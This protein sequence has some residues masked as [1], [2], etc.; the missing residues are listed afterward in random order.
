MRETEVREKA[1]ENREKQSQGIRKGKLTRTN[2][3]VV[4]NMT[5]FR[6]VS[7]QAGPDVTAESC[8][9]LRRNSERRLFWEA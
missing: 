5:L 4:S 9:K 3:K 1:I 8:E 6:G 2:G 7:M